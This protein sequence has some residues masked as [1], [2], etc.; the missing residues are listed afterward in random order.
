ML[1]EQITINIGKDAKVPPPP[2]GHK[3][4]SVINDDKVSWLATWKEN[5]NNNVK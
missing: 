3:W 2:P 4:K 1:P 5:I